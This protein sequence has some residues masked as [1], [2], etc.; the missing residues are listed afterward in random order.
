[1]KS[2]N[3]VQL[4]GRVGS[5]PE[6]LTQNEKILA[7]FSVAT[8][9]SWLDK[10]TSEKR[11]VTEWHR[12]VCFNKVAEIVKNHLKKGAMIYV[13]GKLKTSK[14]QDKNNENRLTTE[15]V[16]DDLIMLDQKPEEKA[17]ENGDERGLE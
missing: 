4:I 13:G 8:N 1:M 5:D 11:T 15:I 7:K 14:W 9:E 16:I 3:A 10:S 6:I 17:A 12:V 2:L